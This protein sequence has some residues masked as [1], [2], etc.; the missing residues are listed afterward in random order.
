MAKRISKIRGRPIKAGGKIGE[1]T[2]AIP[3]G[4][5]PILRRFWNFARNMAKHF[6]RNLLK[7]REDEFL[8]AVRRDFEKW[9]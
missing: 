9:R 1:I 4:L 6:S 2:A 7:N 3:T 8:K 5:S